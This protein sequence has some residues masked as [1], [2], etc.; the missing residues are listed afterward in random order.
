MR[1]R[2]SVRTSRSS[3]AIVVSLSVV[4][5][6][7]FFLPLS[8]FV[9]TGTAVL[10]GLLLLLQTWLVTSEAEDRAA[11]KKADKE[12]DAL[13]GD[14]N[15][16]WCTASYLKLAVTNALFGLPRAMRASFRGVMWWFDAGELAV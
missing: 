1:S 5:G 3:S 15:F 4:F 9:G 10:M 12:L 16:G 11:Q 13:K 2:R 6:Y 7:V 14:R 8:L